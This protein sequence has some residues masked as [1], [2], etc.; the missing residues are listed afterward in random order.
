MKSRPRA[1]VQL[2][3]M[4]SGFWFCSKWTSG[5]WGGH[6]GRRADD[7]SIEVIRGEDRRKEKTCDWGCGLLL[8]IGESVQDDCPAV[9][10]IDQHERPAGY[11]AETSRA[12]RDV[13]IE[14]I[15]ACKLV[16]HSFGG[17]E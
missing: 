13:R 8:D 9:F 11:E 15:L 14:S 16:R 6:E 1:V 10:A 17:R 7:D 12:Q 3:Q 5:A 4:H 2:N